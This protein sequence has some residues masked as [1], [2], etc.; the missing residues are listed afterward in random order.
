MLIETANPQTARLPTAFY[1]VCSVLFAGSCAVSMGASITDFPS[2]AGGLTGGLFW[3][4]IIASV[5]KAL[6]RD[7]GRWLLWATMIHGTL[8]VLRFYIFYAPFLG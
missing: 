2:I 3:P 4:L 8:A 7:F 5:A 1:V 6:K